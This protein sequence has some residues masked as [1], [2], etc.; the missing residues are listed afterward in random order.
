MDELIIK[1]YQKNIITVKNV[2]LKNGL[3]TPIYLDFFELFKHKELLNSFLNS[4]NNFISENISFE[5]IY[6]LDNI[7]NNLCTLLYYKYNY[8]NIFDA[9]S[10]NDNVLILKENYGFTSSSKLRIKNQEIIGIIFLIKYGNT[11]NLEY[12]NYCFL[13]NM[14][15]LLILYQRR[16]LNHEKYFD[17]F[18]TINN[19]YNSNNLTIKI[20]NNSLKSNIVFDTNYIEKLEIKDFV[21]T[22]NFICPHISLIKINLKLFGNNVSSILKLIVYHNVIILDY[23]D[24]NTL[25]ITEN[26]CKSLNKKFNDYVINLI[27][28]EDLLKPCSFNMDYIVIDNIIIPEFENTR[29]SILNKIKDNYFIIGYI[30][31]KSDYLFENKLKIGYYENDESIEKKMLLLNYNL[32]ITSNAKNIINLKQLINTIMN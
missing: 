24:Q 1:L 21:K 5:N 28:I 4:L 26:I 3:I 11:K 19:I 7:A 8:S 22:L 18:K 17:F 9:K 25:E 20:K 23:F 30:A 14:Y 16:I 15:I 10:H 27:N 31:K 32:L 13:D 2:T 29:L 6:G 12:P